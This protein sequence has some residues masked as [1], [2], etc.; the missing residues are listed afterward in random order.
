[1]ITF[2]FVRFIKVL[3]NHFYPVKIITKLD[4]GYLE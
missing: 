1:M 4:L 3:L 2:F